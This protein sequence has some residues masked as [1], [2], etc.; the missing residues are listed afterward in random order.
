MNFSS[1]HPR[2][3]ATAAAACLLFSAAGLLRAELVWTPGVGW[4]VEEDD[5]S[6]VP[7]GYTGLMMMTMAREAHEIRDHA[8]AISLYRRV[9]RD[10][11]TSILAPEAHFQSALIRLERKQWADAFEHYQAIVDDHPDYPGF[12]EV[13]RRQYEIAEALRTGARLRLFWRIPGFRSPERAVQYFEQVVENAPFSEFA[14]EAMLKAA[15]LQSGRRQL[16][17]AIDLYDRFISDYPNHEKASEAYF[18]LAAAFSSRMR[19]PAYDQ[20]ANREAISYYEDFV[21]LYPDHPRAGEAELEIEEMR[22]VLAQSR[23]VLG[24][25]YFLRRGNFPAARVFYN[26]AISISPVSPT[27]EEARRKLVQVERRAEAR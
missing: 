27:A 11:R 8:T 12:G 4:E 3:L 7:Y 5:L 21:L 1:L 26:E 19:G 14:P 13:I 18:G 16:D 15:R 25:F 17:E 22:E 6:G 20:G 23:I 9:I 2:I 10:F 24:D